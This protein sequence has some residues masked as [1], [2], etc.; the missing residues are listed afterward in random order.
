MLKSEHKQTK[1]VFGA[2]VQGKEMREKCKK[3][4]CKHI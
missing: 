4:S 2:T 3:F 1:F